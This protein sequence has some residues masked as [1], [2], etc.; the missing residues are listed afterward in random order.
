MENKSKE[1]TQNSAQKY[2]GMKNVTEGL[3]DRED[4]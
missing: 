4:K 1:V 2:K 3:S